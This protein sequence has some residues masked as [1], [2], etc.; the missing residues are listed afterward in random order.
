MF[1]FSRH[2][3]TR[4]LTET[5]CA[6]CGAPGLI[7]G[8]A[9]RVRGGWR[10][11]EKIDRHDHLHVFPKG[12]MKPDELTR[13]RIWLDPV[14]CPSVV[15]PLEVPPHTLGNREA[16]LLQ[17][18]MRVLMHDTELRQHLGTGHVTIRAGDLAGFR[19][20]VLADPPR[21]AHLFRL[22]FRSEQFVLAA[23]GTWLLCPPLTQT[24]SL[25]AG[26][27]GLRSVIG[28]RMIR[29]LD[30]GEADAFLAAQESRDLEA[31]RVPERR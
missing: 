30:A 26:D 25:L 23:G 21:G 16:F 13:E 5:G 12:R 7:E 20:I 9:L 19:G 11:A 31:A 28:G 27:D 14:D 1:P 17:Q 24:A 18:D 8:T 3:C 15:R 4:R 29:H 10:R 22:V 6:R 2:V